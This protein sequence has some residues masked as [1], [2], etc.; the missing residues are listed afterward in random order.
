MDTTLIV[1]P[2]D[3][4][5]ADF[6][7]L[8]DSSFRRRV[9]AAGP[10]HKGLFVVEGWLGIERLLRSRYPV[11]AVL[12]DA[13]K[14]DRLTELVSDAHAPIYTADRSA[15]DSI[16][17]FPLHRGVVAVAERGL[18]VLASTVIGRAR[19][20]VVVDGVND[21]E[22]LGSIIRNT[23]AL[24]GAGLLLDPTSCDP[25]SRRTIRVSVGHALTL[26]FARVPW[27]DSLSTLRDAGFTTVALTPRPDATSIDELALEPPDRI[28]LIVGAEGP[29]LADNTIDLCD[30]AVRIPMTRGVDSLNVATA[31]AIALHRLAT[32]DEPD[33]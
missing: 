13:A 11:R 4:R 33:G 18:P 28:A 32:P 27:P 9:E 23:V 6:R 22:N 2:N 19:S 15:L 8:N 12:V 20:L 21:A 24:G 31:T 14:S 5:V 25:L 3:P 7:Q 29:G 10:F 26:P 1:D 30:R 17:G 16:V